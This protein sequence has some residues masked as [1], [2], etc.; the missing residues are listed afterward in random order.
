M[1]KWSLISA[2]FLLAGVLVYSYLIHKDS[3]ITKAGTEPSF[4]KE[5]STSDYLT[6]LIDFAHEGYLADQTTKDLGAMSMTDLMATT[7]EMID[8]ERQAV[9]YISKYASSSDS[10][11]S[12]SASIFAVSQLNLIAA[13]Q[14]AL[15]DLRQVTNGDSPKDTQ[16]NLAQVVVAQ[17]K[18]T[19]NFIPIFGLIPYM[20]MNTNSLDA[21]STIGSENPSN[22]LTS[23]ER[24]SILSRI[25]FTF[26]NDIN[27]DQNDIHLL[28]AQEINLLLTSKTYS[29]FHDAWTHKISVI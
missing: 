18:R 8:H 17:K 6:S 5:L 16:Y 23:Q 11:I 9:S 26:G 22:A 4:K 29:D 15:N 1:K 24:A 7:I 3:L 12:T 21:S 2:V 14:Q 25:D 27:L 20:T 13:Q 19:D 28:L 10:S